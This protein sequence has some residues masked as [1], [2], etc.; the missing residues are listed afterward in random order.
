M[1]ESVFSQDNLRQ[2]RYTER[3]N[4]KRQSFLKST[5]YGIGY[6]ILANL[7]CLF[8]TMGLSMFGSNLFF[9]A[10]A[11]ICTAVIFFSLMFTVAWKDGVRERSIIKLGRETHEIKHRWIFVGLIMF[12][13][14]AAPTIVLLLNKLFFEEYDSLFIY[15]FI[16]GSAY[17]FIL[18]FIEPVVTES[19][20]WVE[21]SLRQIDNMSPL[22]PSLMLVYYALVPVATQLGFW[23]G[24]NDKLSKDKIMYK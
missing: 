15:R 22:F 6:I 20:A 11:I 2:H 8:V 23:C 1:G 12:L 10:L 13:F 18:T 24:Y 5:L 7:L 3:K 16:S 14:S 21:T 4:M 19:E 17:P 9:N